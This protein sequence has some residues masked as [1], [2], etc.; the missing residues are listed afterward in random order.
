MKT[1]IVKE[2]EYTL[3]MNEWQHG[4][5]IESLNDL[6]NITENLNHTLKVDYYMT[7]LLNLIEF[8][9]YCKCETKEIEEEYDEDSDIPF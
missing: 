2:R 6:K 7:D 3:V 5:I 9:E 4:H 8:I 1:R